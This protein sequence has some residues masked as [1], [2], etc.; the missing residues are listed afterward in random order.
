MLGPLDC[1]WATVLTPEPLL[2]LGGGPKRQ[3]IHERLGQKGLA[4]DGD[5]WTIGD[6][7]KYVYQDDQV[8]V[9]LDSRK[10]YPSTPEEIKRVQ[11]SRSALSMEKLNKEFGDVLCKPC[12]LAGH[13]DG[14]PL[15]GR[16][17]LRY[18][19]CPEAAGHTQGGAAHKVDEAR[20]RYAGFSRTMRENFRRAE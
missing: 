12:I 5:D 1:D 20:K 4:K 9:F 8:L 7:G 17:Y 3:A 16:S 10:P 15:H 6:K 14:P 11:A 19:T 13:G 18:C 2:P